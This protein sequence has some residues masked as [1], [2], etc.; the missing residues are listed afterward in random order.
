[1]ILTSFLSTLHE[2]G[3]LLLD[4]LSP[5]ITA[6]DRTA[7]LAL[8]QRFYEND[9]LLM[10]DGMPA[11]IAD[12]ALWAAETLYQA[13][14]CALLRD[15]S[16]E[17]VLDRIPHYPGVVDPAAIY[18]AD[19]SLR[20]LPQVLQLAKGLAPADILVTRLR[21]ISSQW[22]LSLVGQDDVP[23]NDAILLQHPALRTVYTER[24]I[25]AK[26]YQRLSSPSTRQAIEETMGA[27]SEHYWPEL[28]ERLQHDY[29]T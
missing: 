2:E 3:V 8:L 9:L 17:D 24:I 26:N 22:P 19:L 14:H 21:E 4:V 18:S 7:A 28:K 12:A 6:E 29:G 1:M 20:Y 10:P 13:V 11:F 27:Y 16:A 25:F 23:A 15:L 5:P